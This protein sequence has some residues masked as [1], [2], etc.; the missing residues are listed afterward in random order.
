MYATSFEDLEVW[1]ESKDLYKELFSIFS[2]YKDYSFKDQLLRASLS[3]MNNIAEGFDR[4]TGKE[5]IRFLYIS[6]G[7]CSEVRS[8]LYLAK[9]FSFVD[10]KEILNL[11]EKTRKISAKLT[12][13]IKN[14]RS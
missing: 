3:I 1:K 11:L 10:E 8:M 14:T 7:S 4:E 13:F 5:L 12:K 6:R 9:D 2:N